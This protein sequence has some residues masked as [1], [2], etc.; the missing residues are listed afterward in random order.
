M[1]KK[2]PYY[3]VRIFSSFTVQ[4]NTIGINT[5]VINVPTI[6]PP[7]A[8][9]P[10]GASLSSPMA[11]PCATG[12]IPAETAI[13]VMSTGRVRILMDSN[14]ASLLFIPACICSIAK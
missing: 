8:T 14:I 6:N 5:S 10:S 12:S 7:M 13:A 11:A 2:Y 1:T 4:I 9:A 3:I